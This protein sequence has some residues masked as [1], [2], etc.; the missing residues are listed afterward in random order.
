MKSFA[1]SQEVLSPVQ[2]TSIAVSIPE[3]YHV[4]GIY[5]AK[6][7]FIPLGG[8]GTEQ[9]P[10]IINLLATPLYLLPISGLQKGTG[11]NLLIVAVEVVE[12]EIKKRTRSQKVKLEERNVF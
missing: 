4:E 3:G 2:Q 1:P 6:A 9:Q 10:I 8:A 11:I 12:K 7:A 5:A